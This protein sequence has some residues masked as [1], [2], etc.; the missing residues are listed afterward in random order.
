LD[1]LTAW[2]GVLGVPA[3]APLAARLAAL[4]GR[5]PYAGR[6]FPGPLGAVEGSLRAHAGSVQRARWAY[7]VA[8]DRAGEGSVLEYLAATGPLPSGLAEL[9]VGARGAQVGADGDRKKLYVYPRD[10]CGILDRLAAVGAHSAEAVSRRAAA[11]HLATGGRPCAF[12]AVDLGGPP[13]HK[14]Y[15][16]HATPA[17][18]AAHLRGLGADVLAAYADG[19]SPDIGSAPAP[20]VVSCRVRDGDLADTTVHLKLDRAPE[21]LGVLA[22][23]ALAEAAADLYR[24]AWRVGLRLCPTYLSFLQGRDGG[25]AT[26]VYYR[27]EDRA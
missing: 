13:A 18:A 24:R 23:P 15:V 26:T 20:A 14:V 9:L 3:P 6:A 10:V 7:A 11:L 4:P 19:W 8:L 5:P 12:V 22:P 17:A 27:L 2:L 1:P 21:R 25:A 16:E